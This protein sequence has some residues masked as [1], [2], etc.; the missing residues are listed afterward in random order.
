M[1]SGS[2][3]S[4]SAPDGLRSLRDHL[5]SASSVSVRPAEADREPVL[6]AAL[7]REG[8]GL[9]RLAEGDRQH[10]GRERIERAGMSRLRRLVEALHPRNGLRRG[11][12]RGLVEDEPAMDRKPLRRRAICASAAPG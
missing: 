12:P 3:A 5:P 8:D 7:D 10:A 11:H 4:I 1:K 6:L 2:S 9:G